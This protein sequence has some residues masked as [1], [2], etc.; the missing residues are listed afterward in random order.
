MNLRRRHINESQRAMVAGRQVTWRGLM[1]GQGRWGKPVPDRCGACGSAELDG[2]GRAGNWDGEEG[3]GLL[4]MACC[5]QCGS[6][7]I[8]YGL[9]CG[10]N[11]RILQ[12]EREKTF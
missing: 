1:S 12:W 9:G 5:Q 6:R 7:W 8:G 4:Y 10:E 11:L 2:L 3:G